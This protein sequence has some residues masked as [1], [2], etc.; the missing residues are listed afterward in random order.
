M[1]RPTPVLA[2][3]VQVADLI[4]R[5]LDVLEVLDAAHCSDDHLTARYAADT[6]TELSNKIEVALN[7][8]GP[9]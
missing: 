4:A 7:T 6:L 9:V 2:G 1:A 5:A 8:G 3:W